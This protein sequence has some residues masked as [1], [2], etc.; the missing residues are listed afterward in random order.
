MIPLNYETVSEAVNK[1]QERGYLANFSVLAEKE[2]LVFHKT[3]VQLSPNEFEID[4]IYRFEGNTDPGD[5]MIVFAVSSI[6]HNMK[7][8]V[9]NAFGMYSDSLPYKMI[10]KLKMRKKSDYGLI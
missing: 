5:E 4:E 9:V 2:C 10:E 3:T 7:G 8:V 1:L 6:E